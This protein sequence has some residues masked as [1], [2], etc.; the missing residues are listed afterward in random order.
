MEFQDGVNYKSWGDREWVEM[1][2]DILEKRNKESG[3][4]SV[5]DT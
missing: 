3:D 1:K 5:W 4:T 2:E